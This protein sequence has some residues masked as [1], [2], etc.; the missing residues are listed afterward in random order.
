[1]ANRKRS[2]PLLSIITPCRNA[3]KTLADCLS[4]VVIAAKYLEVSGYWLE[5]LIVDGSS[6]DGTT[7]IINE[8]C[9]HHRWCCCF[10]EYGGG[11][12]AGMQL[13]LM[14]AQ[15]RYVHVLNADD[16]LVAP[17]AYVDALISANCNDM[18]FVL[19]S[20]VYI[21]RPTLLPISYWYVRLLPAMTSQWH[22]QLRS[23][24]HYP[25]PGFIAERIRY[26]SVG[27]DLAYSY[28]SDY[29]TMQTLL[30]SADVSDVVV[31]TEP[32]VAMDCSGTTGTWR[33]RLKGAF[34]LRKINRQL[35]IRSSFLSRYMVKSFRV[36]M[37]CYGHH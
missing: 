8:H 30:L 6:E 23:G 32:F 9:Q 14:H 13:G 21:R 18:Y 22:H 33:S 37:S 2:T 27:F 7:N 25:H 24:L 34:E 28:A 4:S 10:S 17:Q 19:S 35:G 1:M 12:Y 5:H 31:S 26:L 3:S 29:K 20:I 11:P 36:L 15:G 16:I